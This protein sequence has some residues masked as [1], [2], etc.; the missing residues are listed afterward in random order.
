MVSSICY[1][2]AQAFVIL[3]RA[4]IQTGAYGVNESILD[5]RHFGFFKSF[6]FAIVGFI[7]KAC[8]VRG[9]SLSSREQPQNQPACWIRPYGIITV[10][11]L[12]PAS[13]NHKNRTNNR[14]CL[15]KR[16]FLT[17]K[18]LICCTS[19]INGEGGEFQS[20]ESS[21]KG[22]C[23]HL[24]FVLRSGMA[25][26]FRQAKLSCLGQLY[27]LVNTTPKS[28]FRKWLKVDSQDVPD[29]L[30]TALSIQFIKGPVRLVGSPHL[31]DACRNSVFS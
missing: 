15:V 12:Q 13:R 8:M 7:C 1:R 31:K 6:C 10:P 25:N 14:I 2:T 27:R 19:E 22:T 18:V 5:F 28:S 29:Y 30:R 17:L 4:W 20:F 16:F 23:E 26:C 9:F 3:E 24:S 11:K 21:L